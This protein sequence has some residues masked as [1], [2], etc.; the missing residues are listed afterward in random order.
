M[1]RSQVGSQVDTRL[2][3]PVSCNSR[4]RCGGRFQTPPPQRLSNPPIFSSKYRSRIQIFF[5]PPL[6]RRDPD[7]SFGS[8][9]RWWHNTNHSVRNIDRGNEQ[10]QLPGEAPRWKWFAQRPPW[11]TPR[12]GGTG[13]ITAPS[14][15]LRPHVASVLCYVV[16]GTLWHHD[17]LRILD[18]SDWIP[19]EE[20]APVQSPQLGGTQ[21]CSVPYKETL[22]FCC[23]EHAFHPL[24]VNRRQKAL[25]ECPLC[26][27]MQG[28]FTKDSC[29]A[30]LSPSSSLPS[31]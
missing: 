24:R 16:G 13:Q 30:H 19:F 3:T 20:G 15:C 6:G 17:A 14:V 28:P 18:H 5:F 11:V 21:S 23:Q 9:L 1:A 31:M 26:A 8:H 2:R 25:P 7:R 29:L 12:E 10:P 4:P 22:N 27:L